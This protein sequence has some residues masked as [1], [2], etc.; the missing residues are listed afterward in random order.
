M[1]FQR[2]AVEEFHSRQ[3]AI[4]AQSHPDKNPLQAQA[5]SS[6]T[7]EN[8]SHLNTMAAIKNVEASSGDDIDNADEQPSQR[9][10]IDIFCH[11][12]KS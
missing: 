2:K 10:S 8:G 6:F 1:S 9:M 3:A 11:L 7:I 5:L 12:P 4:E